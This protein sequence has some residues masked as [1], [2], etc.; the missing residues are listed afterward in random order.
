ME[1]LDCFVEFA[2]VSVGPKDDAVPVFL[3]HLEG[4]YREGFG[5]AD[6]RVFIFDDRAVKIYCY[7]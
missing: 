2:S 7:E 3:E 1:E 6:G 4:F 5:L